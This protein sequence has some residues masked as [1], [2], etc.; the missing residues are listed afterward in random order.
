MWSVLSSSSALMARKQN[1]YADRVNRTLS[2]NGTPVRIPRTAPYSADQ[3]RTNAPAVAMLSRGLSPEE[4]RF[5]WRKI[6]A[7]AAA[8]EALGKS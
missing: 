8:I 4:V 5:G 7:M 6:P 2:V 3:I 1:R